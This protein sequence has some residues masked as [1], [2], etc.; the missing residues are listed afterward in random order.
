MSRAERVTDRAT[1]GR[2]ALVA[3]APALT[4]WARRSAPR[5]LPG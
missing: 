4:S 3:G 1:T 2:V 5:T